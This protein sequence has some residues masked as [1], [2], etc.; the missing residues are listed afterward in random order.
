MNPRRNER[1]FLSL[2]AM[3]VLASLRSSGSSKRTMSVNS[4]PNEPSTTS[5]D[6]MSPPAQPKQRMLERLREKLR[7]H[8]TIDAA[9][10][11]VKVV[12]EASEA[13]E[14]LGPLKAASG[15]T[16]ALLDALRV[17]HL[18][19]AW[20]VDMTDRL[21]K[22]MKVN[23]ATAVKRKEEIQEYLRTVETH[24]ASIAVPPVAMKEACMEYTE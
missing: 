8:E 13:N 21:W 6:E 9:S 24:L 15:V 23:S 4:L 17:S 7:R 20:A 1:P 18:Y 14:L 3:S 2:A 11:V 12:K 16:A 5:P 19:V 22:A 10:M